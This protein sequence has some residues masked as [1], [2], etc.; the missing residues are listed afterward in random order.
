MHNYLL[1]KALHIISVVTWF[2]GLFYMPRLFIYHREADDKSEIEKKILQAQFKIMQRRLWRGI[3]IPSS[4]AVLIFG[5]SL[6]QFFWPI[7]AHP[8]LVAKLILVAALYYYQY[9]LHQIFKKQQADL[10][11]F[12]SIKLRAINEISTLFLVTIV[13]LVVLKNNINFIYTLCVIIALSLLMGLA[14]KAYQ[15]YRK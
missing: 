5:S 2:A 7:S 6:L 1:F 15:K 9:F 4:I 13:L 12:S 14:I 10:P 11:S 8:W 3:T